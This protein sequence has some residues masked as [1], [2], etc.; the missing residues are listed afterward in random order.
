MS[1]LGPQFLVARSWLYA[2]LIITFWDTVNTNRDW[3]NSVILAVGKG[4]A[5]VTIRTYVFAMMT[6]YKNT[7][8]L[9]LVGVPYE[10]VMTFHKMLGRFSYNSMIAP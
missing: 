9:H 10:R 6:G 3:G 5:Q 7:M 8:V 1:F 2:W 4:F